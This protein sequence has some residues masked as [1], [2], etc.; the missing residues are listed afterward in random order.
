MLDYDDEY[1]EEVGVCVCVC[2][3]NQASICVGESGSL[4]TECRT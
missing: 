3:L 2:V 4:L 1:N